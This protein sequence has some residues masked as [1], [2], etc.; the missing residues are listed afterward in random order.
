MVY[1]I[2]LI[3]TDMKTN[4]GRQCKCFIVVIGEGTH[5]PQ[6]ICGGQRSPL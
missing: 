2:Y 3:K 1:G 5:T 6:H 4:V